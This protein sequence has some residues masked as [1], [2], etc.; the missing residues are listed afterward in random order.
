MVSAVENRQKKRLQNAPTA[1]TMISA[2]YHQGKD[3]SW[4]HE[5]RIGVRQKT[6]ADDQN[7]VAEV[8][9]AYEQPVPMNQEWCRI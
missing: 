8:L 2:R 7:S 4:P 9:F 5:A 6:R 1:P 3:F